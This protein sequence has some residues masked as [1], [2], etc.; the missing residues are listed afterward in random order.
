M[1]LSFVF[2]AIL[3]Y[4]DAVSFNH[5]AHSI[6]RINRAIAPFIHTVSLLFASDVIS[7]IPTAIN[8]S[9]HSISFLEVIF[10]VSLI[11][12]TVYMEIDS[13]SISLILAPFAIVTVPIHVIKFAIPTRHIILSLSLVIGT[14]GKFLHS[15]SIPICFYS[16]TCINSPIFKSKRRSVLSFIG[17]TIYKKLF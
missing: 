11:S 6:P 2:P 17:K 15:K 16:F 1:S 14:I 5:I 9:F 3:P 13:V 8:P 12:C 4:I 7:F 10:P